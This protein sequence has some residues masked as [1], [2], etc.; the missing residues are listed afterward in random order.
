[1]PTMNPL[2]GEIWQVNLNPTI[3]REQSGIR[4]ALVVSANRFNR[5]LA[6]LVVV[7]P[8]TSKSKGIPYHVQIRPPEGGIK[9][10]SYIKPE[11]V[12]SISKQRFV[13]QWGNVS[14]ATMTEVADM[15]RVTLD[16]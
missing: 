3:G 10:T 14:A 8:L 4:P 11:D 9:T 6:E 15:L 7:V 13:R 16:L 1:M 5:S 12:R 2:R